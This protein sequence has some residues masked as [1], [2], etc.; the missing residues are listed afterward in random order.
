MSL[1]AKFITAVMILLFFLVA[2]M[3]FLIERREEKAIFEEQKSKGVLIA[4]NI[5]YLNLEPFMFW[6]VEGVKKNIQEKIDEK[7]L[8]VVFFDQYSR[9]FAASDFAENNEQISQASHL[10]GPVDQDTYYF[11]T[12]EIQY[13]DQEKKISVLEIE[14]PIFARGSST[15]WGSIKIG[16]SLEDMQEEINQTRFILI[17]IGMGGLLVGIGGAVFLS[18]RITGPLKKLVDGTIRIS[19]GDFSKKIKV[20]SK[21][22]IRQLAES[23]NEMSRQLQLARKRM[24]AANKKLVQA[25]ML[26]SIGRISASIAHEIRNPLTSANLNIQKVLQSDGLEEIEKE[27]LCLSQE[28]ISHIEKFIK[29]L[30]NFTRVSELNKDN[31]SVQEIIDESIKMISNS[32]EEKNIKLHTLY[33][34]AIPSLYV[35]GDKLRQVLLNLLRNAREAVEEGGKIKISASPSR[36]DEKKAVK[37]EVSDNGCGIPEKEK[38]NIFEPFYTT[39]SSGIGLGLANAKKIIE[40]HRGTIKVKEVKEK[41][42]CFEITLPVEEDK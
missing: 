27:H 1:R 14:V 31:F 34:D 20:S 11:Q 9:P 23:F 8:Y 3:L 17:L 25:E 12:K 2:A 22:E 13:P 28:G 29:E 15:Q 30:L 38:E 18:D 19:R 37:I 42:I 21:D 40:Q 26:A 6:D 16:L 4:K 35:D 32:L 36:I 39:K 5:A 33:Q 41:G 7:L 10:K 24:E